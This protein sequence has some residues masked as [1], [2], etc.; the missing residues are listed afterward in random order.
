MQNNN[1]N[2]L[3][4]YINS[5]SWIH[6]LKRVLYSQSAQLSWFIGHIYLKYTC[7]SLKCVY[8]ERP[9]NEYITKQ[10]AENVVYLDDFGIIKVC[11]PPK[12]ITT[13]HMAPICKQPF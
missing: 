1:K 9:Q 8:D 5:P 7:T 10:T 6:V 4:K 13:I 3:F 12:A 11:F 2:S